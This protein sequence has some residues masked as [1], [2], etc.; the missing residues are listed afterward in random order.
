MPAPMCCWARSTC[1]GN[2][3]QAQ[4]WYEKALQ[5]QPDQALAA[6]NLAFLMLETGQNV[7]VALTLAQTARRGTPKS[8]NSADTLVGRIT[9]KGAYAMARDLLEDALRTDANDPD[10]QLHLGLVYQKLS[11]PKNAANHLKKVFTLAPNSPQAQQA[12]KALG[13]IG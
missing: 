6:N 2:R 12:R 10:L 8:P 5:L 4:K 9:T 3:P 13:E 7:D 1:R 11:D